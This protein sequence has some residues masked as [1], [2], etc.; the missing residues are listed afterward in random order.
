MLWIGVI[1][2]PFLGALIGW[3]TNLLAVRLLFRPYR[4][5]RLPILGYCFQGMLPKYRFELAEKVGNLIQKELL[6][7]DHL[8]NYL[9]SEELKDEL[10]HL[11]EL[12]VRDRIIDKLPAFLP[13]A[14]KRSFGDFLAEQVHRELPALFNELVNRSG[15]RLKN[16]FE[17]ARTIEK[18]LN[19]FE[20]RQLENIIFQVA[21]RELRHIEILGGII[22][23]LI[24]LLQV[25]LMIIIKAFT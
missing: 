6:S 21:G 11:A 7:P 13:L 1:L 8:F 20:L 10:I 24:G 18:R 5:I 2:L 9:C 12:A 4:P 16:E 3:F 15:H 25:G 14:L 23:F 19:E 22:G 17:L